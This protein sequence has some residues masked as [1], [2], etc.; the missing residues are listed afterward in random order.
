MRKT[1]KT[2]K[3]NPKIM[4]EG[5]KYKISFNDV[6]IIHVKLLKDKGF[7]GYFKYLKSTPN[8]SI[9]TLEHEDKDCFHLPFFCFNANNIYE[10]I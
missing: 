1:P 3:I 7:D 9:T 6:S 5:K 4:K 2:P 10:E 8:K